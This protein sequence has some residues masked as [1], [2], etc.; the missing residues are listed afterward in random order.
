MIGIKAFSALMLLACTLQGCATKK[1]SERDQALQKQAQGVDL[2]RSELTKIAGQYLGEFVSD[3][4][5][6]HRVRLILEVRD[7]PE[8]GGTTDPVVVPKLLG[9]LRFILGNE[10]MGENIDAPIQSSEFI[11]A[12]NQLSLVIKHVQFG[13]LV[14]SGTVSEALIVGS[15]NASSVSRSGR[16]QVEKEVPAAQ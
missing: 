6:A 9:S 7:V 5:I 1:L 12:R 16:I 2:K 14:V 8:G 3:D 15:W 13:E 10:E 11:K 4:G